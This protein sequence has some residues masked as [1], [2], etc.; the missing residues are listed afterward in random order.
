MPVHNFDYPVTNLAEALHVLDP[1]TELDVLKEGLY[2]DLEEIRNEDFFQNIM[3]LLG[4]AGGAYFGRDICVNKILL[5]GHRGSG[6]SVELQ[7]IAHDLSPFYLT[8][9]VNIEKDLVRYSTV[10]PEDIYRLLIIK[11]YECIAARN[12]SFDFEALRRLTDIWNEEKER[13]TKATNAQSFS[14]GSSAEFG[15]SAFI[16]KLK[17]SLT[18]SVTSN[19]EETTRLRLKVKANIQDILSQWNAQLADIRLRL[20]D[21]GLHGVIYI[22]DGT[23]K[24]PYDVAKRIFEQD[25][26]ILQQINVAM[27]MASPLL[28][29]HEVSGGTPF[30]RNEIFPMPKL[31][32]QDK[33][34][35]FKQIITKRV[36]K[37][38][39]FEPD[40]L[41]CIVKKSGGSIRQMLEVARETVLSSPSKPADTKALSKALYKKG[42]S[43][44][45]PLT[46]AHVA[47]LRNFT[48]DFRR[49]EKTIQE[50]LFGLVLLAQNGHAIIN[51]VLQPFLDDSDNYLC[52]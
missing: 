4:V 52:A 31:G 33:I 12:I 41:D 28:S 49:G 5:T 3:T 23:E 19:N 26:P 38:T 18:A 22:L 39:F 15:I 25:A 6:K 42:L 44:W 32:S 46:E 11:L 36:D 48:G 21:I 2:V 51:P 7:R 10:T 13:E 35:I 20:E 17:A 29:I 9:T 24:I 27:I 40:V 14:A 43:L 45:R 34:D 50:M 8:V 47:A 30:F 37:A 1:T 16:A